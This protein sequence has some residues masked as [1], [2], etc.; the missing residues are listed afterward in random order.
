MYIVYLAKIAKIPI[1]QHLIMW[2][3]VAGT[4]I[5]HRKGVLWA[6]LKLSETILHYKSA[7]H[8]DFHIFEKNRFFEVQNLAYKRKIANFTKNSC[9]NQMIV[10]LEDNPLWSPSP[11]FSGKYIPTIT[12]HMFSWLWN[13]FSFFKNV[14]FYHSSIWNWISIFTSW[15]YFHQ[16]VC[17]LSFLTH[18]RTSFY[19]KKSLRYVHLKSCSE[20]CYRFKFWLHWDIFFSATVAQLWTVKIIKRW[21]FIY[22]QKTLSLIQGNHFADSSVSHISCVQIFQ[23]SIPIEFRYSEITECWLGVKRNLRLQYFLRVTYLKAT[24]ISQIAKNKICFLKIS[25]L[26]LAKRL[27]D[28]S[29][30][31]VE[32]S[33]DPPQ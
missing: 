6:Y 18:L 27:A 20:T 11:N 26:A 25:R 30:K 17:I 14:N 28:T 33:P 9:L 13:F 7:F 4:I 8:G 15:N 12:S 24:R 23:N 1:F 22:G 29:L 21:H 16:K 10:L 2:P 31:S 19:L 5:F 3:E 32:V